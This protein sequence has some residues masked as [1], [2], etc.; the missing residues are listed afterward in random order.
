MQS[1]PWLTKKISRDTIKVQDSWQELTV[2]YAYADVHEWEFAC[3]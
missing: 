1:L 2:G 3:I